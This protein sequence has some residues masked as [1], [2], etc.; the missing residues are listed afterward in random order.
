M[1]LSPQQ[2]ARVEANMRTLEYM[3]ADGIIKREKRDILGDD[4]FLIVGLGGTGCAALAELKKKLS[5]KVTK[6]SIEKYIR[7]LAVDAAHNELDA[8]VSKGTFARSEVCKLPFEGVEQQIHN[9]SAATR[10]WIHPNLRNFTNN[11]FNG[12]GAGARRQFGRALLTF[13]N[14]VDALT[15]SVTTQ[16]NALVAG[17][18][19]SRC[20]LIVLTGIAGGTGSGTVIDATYIIRYL[21]GKEN[22][23]SVG[24]VFGFVFLPPAASDTRQKP[25]AIQ[26]GNSNAYAALKEIE[27]HMTMT[28]RGE[29]FVM[30]YS[31]T[32]VRGEN[33][34]D[35]CY[36]IDGKGSHI[37]HEFPQTTAIN[38]AADCI[39]NMIAS[40]SQR[41][42]STTAGGGQSVQH[43][44][45]FSYL[46][47]VPKKLTEFIGTRP[48]EIIPRDSYYIYAATGYS[49]M[50]IPK[51]L[52]QI[53][54]AKKVFDFLF[55]SYEKHSKATESAAEQVLAQ[56]GLDNPME[57][58]K[59]MRKF[60]ENQMLC[61]PTANAGDVEHDVKACAKKLYE[62]VF[63][64]FENALDAAFTQYGPYYLVNLTFHLGAC[65]EKME[66][67]NSTKKRK[68]FEFREVSKILDK[69]RTY[70]NEQNT[71]T[72]EVY[73]C[74]IDSFK[75]I[76]DRTNA[77]LTDTA[78]T[79]GPFGKTYSWTPLR[80]YDGNESGKAAFEY[81]DE[82]MDKKNVA[83]KAQRF[84]A[85]LKSARKKWTDL[86]KDGEFNASDAIRDFVTRTFKDIIKISLE[87]FAAICFTGSKDAR[88]LQPTK[89]N[90][91]GEATDELK[92]AADMIIDLLRKNAA[93]LAQ[94][95]NLS[96]F[97]GANDAVFLVLPEE[98]KHLNKLIMERMGSE[99]KKAF[100]SRN[101]DSFT[102]FNNF[103]SLPL[104]AF[105]WALEGEKAY[106]NCS[107]DAE[108]GQHMNQGTLRWRNFPNLIN[109]ALWQMLES[110]YRFE[111]EAHLSA[112]VRTMMDTARSYGLI[113]E[114]LAD[115]VRH[116][117]NFKVLLLDDGKSTRLGSA[118]QPLGSSNGDNDNT[119]MQAYQIYRDE[120]QALFAG[121]GEDM[122]VLDL[123]K[124]PVMLPLQ[125]KPTRPSN[126]TMSAGP[127]GTN[128]PADWDW[129]LT[130]RFMRK[131]YSTCL[132]LQRTLGVMEVLRVLVTEH[133]AAVAAHGKELERRNRF[134]Q[135]YG[136]E[137]LDYDDASG[138]WVYEN[139]N[140]DQDQ[141]LNALEL[142]AYQRPYHFY[143][144]M[145]RLYALPDDL[146]D[147][148]QERFT[149]I[150]K[151]KGSAISER[152]E[153]LKAELQSISD[154]LKANAAAQ[155][156]KNASGDSELVDTL[157]KFY[158]MSVDAL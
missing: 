46:P 10:E 128:P 83:E 85:E 73:T 118:H 154:T 98:T 124:L 36:L 19:G 49:E 38:T 149:D 70:V 101:S 147:Y 45:I 48:A 14:S 131:M 129:D 145:E 107:G 12:T 95:S 42:G 111:E 15:H 60:C 18:G 114:E 31:G 23:N 88:A 152:Q 94:S 64:D 102:L 25:D 137:L 11:V 113:Q 86:S 21:L 33:I 56:V 123:A 153:K 121:L 135:Y 52:L 89:E 82:L 119:V 110:G 35:Y 90:P 144:M 133:N 136:A 79:S 112:Y 27:Y 54:A 78:E 53:Y 84:V 65:L 26:S 108:V 3:E 100:Y 30:N 139:E 39:I 37:I 55:D 47:D 140:G 142:L 93:V 75:G 138:C 126:S 69:L 130:C 34:F 2:R 132:S 158:R 29:E 7:Y 5:Q 148:W 66:R 157:R 44:N 156:L 71:D 63:A 105:D 99:V 96:N 81:L 104:N 51:D 74:V 143:Y 103:L 17:K 57:L 62:Q 68:S 80:P 76:L 125:A 58:Q 4:R 116:I 9:P 72:F 120:A 77:V 150:V 50:V 92:K 155:R 87:D 59:R 40:E 97:S 109:P 115:S 146:F 41:E 67:P 134:A 122:G 106:A 1:A 6:A 20:S 8:Y 117:R 91:E 22:K 16:F 24:Q 13:G 151:E 32:Q 127:E 141:L 61:L 28:E 43:M